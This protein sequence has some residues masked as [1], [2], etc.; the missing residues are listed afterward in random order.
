MRISL[1]SLLVCAVL[2]TVIWATPPDYKTFGREQNTTHSPEEDELLRVW[3]FYVGQGDALLIQLPSKFSYDSDGDGTADQ[4]IDILV[5]TGP[6]TSDESR[7][8]RT[9]INTVY[10]AGSI[11]EHLVITHHDQDH[12]GGIP[13]LFADEL[14]GVETI[15]HNGLASYRP[16]E[17]G[18]PETGIPTQPA[19]FKENNSGDIT[20]GM[21]FLDSDGQVRSQF[22][23]DNLAELRASFEGDELHGVYHDLAEA[24]LSKTEPLAVAGFLRVT[25]GG[26]FINE[27]E[28]QH[29]RGLDPGEIQIDPVW[30]LDRPRQYGDW[31]ESIN[32]NSVTFRLAYKDFAMLFT[33]DHNEISEDELLNHLGDDTDRLQCDVLKVP[34]H[35]SSHA[36]ESFFRAD[37]LAPV[38]SV[39]SQGSRGFL[40]NWEHPSTDVISW[41]GRSHR[42]Y[43]TYIH[44]RRFDYDDFPSRDER[45]PLVEETHVLVE[46]DG[47][48][49]RIVEVTDP[50][51]VQSTQQTRRGNGTRWIKAEVTP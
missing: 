27:S 17:K 48:W 30:P 32:G 44:E 21:A 45:L 4:R 51:S 24:V 23:I 5:D 14:V 50:T 34:H 40:S 8:I 13:D 3:A 38:V 31:G 35:G 1:C 25:D 16:G 39:A 33:G 10:P 19:I 46:T 18:F 7:Q 9:L 37:A 47:E 6:R 20:R 2:G 28:A 36:A 22:L 12:V 29:N 42:V 49:F 11:I 43:H 41:L 15:Y 26:D